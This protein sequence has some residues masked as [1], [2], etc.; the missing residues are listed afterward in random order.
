LKPEDRNAQLT[1]MQRRLQQYVLGQPFTG[2]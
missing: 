1:G 2:L